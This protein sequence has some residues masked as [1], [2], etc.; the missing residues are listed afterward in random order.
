VSDRSDSLRSAAFCGK[1]IA[2]DGEGVCAV[3]VCQAVA[4]VQIKAILSAKVNR[5][6]DELNIKNFP[7]RVS[8]GK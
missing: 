5:L 4:R 8:E 2:G 3:A 7:L 1:G 6:Q